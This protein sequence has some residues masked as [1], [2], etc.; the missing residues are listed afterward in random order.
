MGIPLDD[1][2][3]EYYYL[4]GNGEL[5]EG[6]RT[7]AEYNIKEES[8]LHLSFRLLGGGVNGWARNMRPRLDGKQQQHQDQQHPRHPPAGGPPVRAVPVPNGEVVSQ[9]HVELR[10]AYSWSSLSPQWR[11]SWV[12]STCGAHWE[13]YPVLPGH[14]QGI[15]EVLIHWRGQVGQGYQNFTCE[16]KVAWCAVRI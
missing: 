2:Y 7:L 10:R 14:P 9:Q 6:G 12:C 13:C 1:Y 8:T 11:W 5:S 4:V 16:C 3:L 15:V